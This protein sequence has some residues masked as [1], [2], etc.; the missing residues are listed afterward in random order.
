MLEDTYPMMIGLN[1][2]KHDFVE[3]MFVKEL[4][5]LSSGTNNTFYSM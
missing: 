2:Q 1:Q 5:E 3:Q 4:G